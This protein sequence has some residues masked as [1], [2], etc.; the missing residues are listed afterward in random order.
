MERGVLHSIIEVEKEI[1]KK[2]NAEE[3]RSRESIEKVR[4]E[5]ESYV[6]EEEKSLEETLNTTLETARK[7]AVK[8][9]E[10]IVADAAVRAKEI[11]GLTD[12]VLTKILLEKMSRIL[13]EAE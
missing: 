10:E 6:A 1:L 11:E 4:K 13:P 2:I 3:L 5:V 8:K 9:A 12:S 7:D